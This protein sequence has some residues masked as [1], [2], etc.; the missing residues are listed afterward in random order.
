MVLTTPPLMSTLPAVPAS[1]VKLVSAVL[2][3]TAPV[4][5]VAPDV[6]TTSVCAPLSV[7]LNVMAPLPMLVSTVAVPKVATSP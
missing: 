1:V 2:L 7:L 4:K 3:P 5:V 6:L